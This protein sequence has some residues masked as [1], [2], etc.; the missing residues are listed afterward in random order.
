MSSARRTNSLTLR[1]LRNPVAVVSLAVLFVL[2]AAAV[3]APLLAPYDP[4]AQDLSASRQGP[5]A[6]HLLGTDALG[7]DLLSRIMWG[8]RESLFGVAEALFVMLAI[9]V[10]FG[11]LTAY[12]GGIFDRIVLGVIDI[13]MAI[14]GIIITLATLAIFNSSM[15]AA[16]ISVGA[17]ASGAFT[18]V[19]R[20][21]VLAVRRELFVSAAVVS[22]LRAIPIMV[23]HVVP[24]AKG[25]ILVQASLFAAATLGIQ[26]GL[27][28]LAFGPPPPAPTWGG[29]VAEAATMLATH[30]WMFVP[31]GGVIAIAT[32]ALGLLG[33][34]IRDAAAE[35]AGSARSGAA[36][37]QNVVGPVGAEPAGD[38]ALLSVRGL[39]VEFGSGA[40]ATTVVDGASFDVRRGE[41]VGL[42]GESGS[43]KTVTALAVLGLLSAGGRITAGSVRFDGREL[44]DDAAAMEAVR[45]SGIAFI[46]QEPMVALDP[47]FTI[48]WQLVEAIR[49]HDKCDKRQARERALELLASV[50]LRDP[51]KV[52]ASYPFQ[53]SGGMA[54]RVVIARALAGRPRL[55]I[56]D[57]PTTALDV[58]VQAEILALLRS[59]QA[60]GM[61]VILVTHDWGVVAETCGRALVMYAG[62]VV[63]EAPL[64]QMIH[65]PR[66]PYTRGLLDSSPSGV[67]RGEILPTIG[68]TVP[69]P[70]DW[71]VGCRFAARCPLARDECRAAP[72]PM[73]ALDDDRRSRCIRI[74]A[75]VASEHAE[76][77]R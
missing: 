68:G 67:R 18:R 75:L 15:T 27:S 7:R 74:P 41:F 73:V 64:P 77:T 5:S 54:Q 23:R 22:G 25:A 61:A 9:A 40:E 10:P 56:A 36:G 21:S 13:M 1:L 49:H 42:V 62:Q 24:H 60:D 34:A 63:E 6:A 33:D 65:A 12:L 19:F 53:V 32:L 72:I 71:P 45:G 28:F 29:M 30:P 76:A 70:V 20:S 31:T 39:T 37:E 51:E 66:H 4:I 44:R 11:V 57:E 48:G 14:P 59:M 52:F 69:S 55:L 58:T 46:S 38:D 16:M 8:G 35:R 26:T 47:S 43:G 50:K 3:F 17:L 2:I